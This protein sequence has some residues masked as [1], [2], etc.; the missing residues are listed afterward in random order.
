MINKKFY[1]LFLL[2]F[3]VSIVSASALFQYDSRQVDV[4]FNFTQN[5]YESTYITLSTIVTPNSTETINVNMISTGNGSFYYNYTPNQ[6]GRYDF[7]GVSDGCSKTFAVYIDITSNGQTYDTG[8][9]LIR[10][11][12]AIFFILMMLG[13]YKISSSINYEQW[14]EKIKEKHAS[15]NVVK[16][17]LAAIA[18]NIMKNGLIV[19]FLL[20]LPIMVISMDLVYIYNI[21]SI[22]LYMKS[23]L[24]LYI[25]AIMV[26][27]VSFLGFLFEWFL[28]A[29]EELQN[30]D[31][32]IDKK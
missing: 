1:T 13:F 6:I 27:A 7:L 2:V 21:T 22:A 28:D 14:Y 23:L 18:Y 9:S 32:G 15:K 25:A 8:D 16:F 3:L 19:Y 26:V 20:G 30:V 11:F 5:C 4:E 10:I 12:I 29:I 17:A 31:W 24:F